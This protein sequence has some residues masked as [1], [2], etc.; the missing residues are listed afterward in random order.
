MEQ[1][2]LHDS[3]LKSDQ[4]VRG[5]YSNQPGGGRA[6]GQQAPPLPPLPLQAAAPSPFGTAAYQPPN[7]LSAEDPVFS[8]SFISSTS[9]RV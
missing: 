7:P 2:V 3:I 4:E 5:Y 9:S 8:P 1:S 6:A